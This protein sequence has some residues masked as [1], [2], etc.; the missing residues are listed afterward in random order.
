[1]TG[2]WG[3]WFRAEL[4]GV[5]LLLASCL[6]CSH[7]SSPPVALLTLS[8]FFCVDISI[9][10]K[11]GV[12]WL[13]L[14]GE[15]QTWSRASCGVWSSASWG[16]EAEVALPLD[17]D[18]R[19]LCNW[20]ISWFHLFCVCVF[21]HCCGGWVLLGS[22]HSCHWQFFSYYRCIVPWLPSDSV[23]PRLLQVCSCSFF[24]FITII[25]VAW[26]DVWM[27][28]GLGGGVIVEHFSPF[29]VLVCLFSFVF[30][31]TF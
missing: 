4:D 1:V 30:M 12:W 20:S 28:A 18:L 27:V 31:S 25:G 14:E 3:V 26:W 5:G 15:M 23:N 11:C 7:V 13:F 9:V 17:S 6:A 16:F 21:V 22:F 10:R 2:I 29:C 24:S 19:L 8:F